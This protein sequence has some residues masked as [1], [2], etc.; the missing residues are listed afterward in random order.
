MCLQILSKNIS[1]IFQNG[2]DFAV[3]DRDGVSPLKLVHLD[4]Q[5]AK[6]LKS[7]YHPVFVDKS[8][9]V[10]QQTSLKL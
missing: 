3:S 7:R 2:L 1:S 4:S 10:P 6:T 8:G 5:R 9:I